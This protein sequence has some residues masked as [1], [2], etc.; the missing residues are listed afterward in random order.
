MVY[1]KDS[2]EWISASEGKS[3][4][5]IAHAYAQK[6]VIYASDDGVIRAIEVGGD[7]R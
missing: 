4:V 3:A 7:F 2:R 1:N 6:S 5:D